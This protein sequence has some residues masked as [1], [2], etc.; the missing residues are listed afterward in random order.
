MTNNQFLNS[1]VE[2]AK[3]IIN[4]DDNYIKAEIGFT[5][6]GKNRTLKNKCKRKKVIYK[7]YELDMLSIPLY[8]FNKWGF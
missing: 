5:I 8:S 3:E 4:N 2:M 7:S 6:K 1:I